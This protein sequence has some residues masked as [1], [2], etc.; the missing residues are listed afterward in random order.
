MRDKLFTRNFT[1]LIL[2]QVSSLIGNYTLKFALSMYVLEQTGSA[3]IYATLLAVAM[4]PTILLSPFGGILADR[5]NRRNIM[6]GLDTL[7]GLTVLVAGLVL[8]FG[9]DIWV[10]GALLVI[11]SVLAAFESPTVQACIPQMLSGNNLMKGNAAVN[12]VQAIAGLIT[13]FLGSLVYAAFGLTPVLWGTVACF[14]LTAILE[15]FIRL[16]YQKAEVTMSVR[17]IIRED[18]SVSIHFLRREQPGILKLLLLATLASLFVAGTVVVGFPYLVRTVLGLSA[19]HYGAAESV[20]GVAA[21]L[22]SLFVGIT[23]QK[24][25]LRWLAFVFMGLGLSLIPTG[26]AFLLPVEPLGIYI[27]LLVMFSL[28]QFG[29]SLFSTY[30]ISV[31]QARTPEH[32]MGKIMSYVFTLSMCAQPAGQIIYGALFDWFSDSPYWV[33]IPSGLLVCAIGLASSKFFVNFE[34]N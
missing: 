7:S 31:I 10:I 20:M 30:A 19:E 22:G 25:R 23:A 8:P 12:Q 16:D 6:V 28:G 14:F 18:F 34:K 1:F 29:C 24:F 3:S 21:V 32:L 17:E 15:C 4:L 9:H 26:I 5:A 2:G 11:L 13:P 33:L 27:I